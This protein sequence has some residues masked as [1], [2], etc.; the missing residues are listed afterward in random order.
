MFGIMGNILICLFECIPLSLS[1]SLS[2]SLSLSLS[3]VHQWSVHSHLKWWMEGWSLF[4]L[5]GGDLQIA[6][7]LTLSGITHPLPSLSHFVFQ[8]RCSPSAVWE[9]IGT[10][11]NSLNQSYH[12]SI[13][14]VIIPKIHTMLHL[15]KGI[16]H[17]RNILPLFPHVH[18]VPNHY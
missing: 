15:V 12:N 17:P 9:M 1:L 14:D 11:F 8:T 2:R 10:H 16:V 5:T 18:P 13:S 4:K 3:L 7:G 6:A